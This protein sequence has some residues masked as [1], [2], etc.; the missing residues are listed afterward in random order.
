M[1]FDTSRFRFDAARD[2]LGVVMQQGRVQLD[3]D[4]NELVA[5]VTRRIHAGT[6]DTV[7]RAVVPRETPDG[8][9][10]WRVS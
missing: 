6:M 10:I 5:E 9:R 4:W 3:A 2:F 1:T 8:F 7:G